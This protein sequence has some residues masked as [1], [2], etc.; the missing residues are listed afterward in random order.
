MFEPVFASIQ[1]E[2]L[3]KE[4]VGHY[5]M[6]KAQAA[7]DQK[8]DKG[9]LIKQVHRDLLYFLIN[10]VNSRINL[11]GTQDGV[12][13]MSQELDN[14]FLRQY[15]NAMFPIGLNRTWKKQEEFIDLG[16]IKNHAENNNM[17]KEEHWAVRATKKEGQQREKIIKIDMNEL[18]EFLSITKATFG[19]FRIRVCEDG[20]VRC[21]LISVIF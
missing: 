4:M 10:V 2:A 6:P 12:H 19:A 11:K 17:N 7:L 5:C 20:L 16:P 9:D 3:S 8:Q 13:L 14:D 21:F 1:M 15:S 18:K